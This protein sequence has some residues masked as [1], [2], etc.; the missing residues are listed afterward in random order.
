MVKQGLP[1]NRWIELFH[2][3]LADRAGSPVAPTHVAYAGVVYRE[4][5][6]GNGSTRIRYRA[7]W[8]DDNPALQNFIRLL[9]ERCPPAA[10]RKRASF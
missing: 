8:R 5:R 6:D 2:N 9:E 1:A 7:Y 4:A 10:N 3:W